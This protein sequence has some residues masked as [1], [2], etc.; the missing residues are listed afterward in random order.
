MLRNDAIE[1]WKAGV[2]AVHGRTLVE[3]SL[4]LANDQL[5]LQDQTFNLNNFDRILIVGGGKFSHFMAEG[6]ENVL[7][8]DVSKQKQLSGL[9]TVPDG[10]NEQVKLGF[11]ESAQCRPAGVNLPTD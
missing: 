10:S 3:N 4:H 11:I 7:G 2:S 6:I 9:V 8:P 5:H 1:I